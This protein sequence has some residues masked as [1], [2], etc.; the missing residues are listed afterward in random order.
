M[1]RS[2]SSQ[3]FAAQ[4]T[5]PRL[6]TDDGT[7]F[8]APRPLDLEHDAVRP[9]E[10]DKELDL[11]LSRFEHLLEH[12]WYQLALSLSWGPRSTGHT[13]DLGVLRS[14][15]G[16][17]FV[18][19]QVNDDAGTSLIVA[20]L[21]TRVPSRLFASFLIDYLSSRGAA[22]GVSLPSLLPTTTW[23]ACPELASHS[24]VAAGLLGLVTPEGSGRAELR[25]AEPPMAVSSFSPGR[26]LP[27]TLPARGARRRRVG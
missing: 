12:K 13:L 19:H 22:Y 24:V 21:S 25:P 23:I 18:V 9:Q 14:D 4:F 15:S 7:I 17:L 16:H 27:R 8:V 3:H 6:S 2:R 10:L 5:H 26:N 11:S 20:C 1:A